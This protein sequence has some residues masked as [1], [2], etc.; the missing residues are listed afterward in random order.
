VKANRKKNDKLFRGFYLGFIKLHILHHARVEPLYGKEFRKELERHG[1]EISYG[2]LYPIFHNLEKDGY[3]GS[4]NKKVGGKIR[5][6]YTITKA[7]RN[8]LRDS[9]V[10]ARE[11]MNELAD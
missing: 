4:E 6:Y 10:K 3:L 7:G 2:T 5:K 11:L 1:Y 9:I 8:A